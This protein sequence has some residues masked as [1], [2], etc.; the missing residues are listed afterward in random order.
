MESIFTK[1][2]QFIF[3]RN[4]FIT[5]AAQ[6]AAFKIVKHV[7]DIMYSHELEW[8]YNYPILML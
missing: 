8:M 7:E 3:L 4:C 6:Y 2:L 5:D 1:S